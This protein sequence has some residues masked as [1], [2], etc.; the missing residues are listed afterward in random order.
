MT[1]THE[2]LKCWVCGSGRASQVVEAKALVQ[3]TA[4]FEVES[5]YQLCCDEM[6]CLGLSALWADRRDM[7]H[8]D[9]YE[10]RSRAE[11]EAIS[12]LHL[13]EQVTR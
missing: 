2:N 9:T 12:G 1:Y 10:L 6:V 13:P 11:A 7:I 3:Y 4:A 8:V 5:Y